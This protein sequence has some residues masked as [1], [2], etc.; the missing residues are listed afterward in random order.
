MNEKGEPL[1][2][3]GVVM[4]LADPSLF[5]PSPSK[6]VLWQELTAFENMNVGSL[7]HAQTDT[8]GRFHITGLREGRYL[9]VVARRIV[10]TEQF[11]IAYRFVQIPSPAIIVQL[12]EPK[13]TLEGSPQILSEALPLADVKLTMP[14]W[15]DYIPYFS[16]RTDAA[17]NFQAEGIPISEG[18]PLLV[19]LLHRNGIATVYNPPKVWRYQ[20]TLLP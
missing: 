8:Q 10:K 9:L 17:G 2:F 12:S 4:L 20:R 11:L 3:A 13:G 6:E 1:I 7:P 16:M 15:C 5:S 14:C 19:R 18:V